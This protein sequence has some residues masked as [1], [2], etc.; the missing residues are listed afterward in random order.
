MSGYPIFYPCWILTISWILINVPNDVHILKMSACDAP[1]LMTEMYFFL[2]ASKIHVPLMALSL[3]SFFT[4][5]GLPVVFSWVLTSWFNPLMSSCFPENACVHTASS[6]LES[7]RSLQSITVTSQQRT[8]KTSG[9]LVVGL[10]APSTRWF[11]NPQARS[12]L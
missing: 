1:E 9:R 12:W 5:L 6:R 7:W 11:T 2:V 4:F 3:L 10:M 8:W